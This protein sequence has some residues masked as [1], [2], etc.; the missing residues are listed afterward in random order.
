MSFLLLSARLRLEC[1]FCVSVAFFKAL[2][3][4]FVGVFGDDAFG[5]GFGFSELLVVC[6]PL[7]FKF[8]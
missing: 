8:V 2:V 6:F 5:F 7:R 4:Y 1:G 3:Q